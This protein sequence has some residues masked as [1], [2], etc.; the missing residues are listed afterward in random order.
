MASCLAWR[1]NSLSQVSPQPGGVFGRREEDGLK[2]VEFADLG[3]G[4]APELGARLNA[5]TSRNTQP[6][7]GPAQ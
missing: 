3:A 4:W 7:L 1:C 2:L 6:S 5:Q